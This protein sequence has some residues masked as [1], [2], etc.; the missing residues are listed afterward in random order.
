MANY[1]VKQL[2]AHF[3][4]LSWAWAWYS[5]QG[6]L[7]WGAIVT[8]TDSPNIYLRPRGIGTVESKT[9]KDEKWNDVIREVMNNHVYEEYI[10]SPDT[11]FAINKAIYD[12]LNQLI[13][14]DL[15]GEHIEYAIYQ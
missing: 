14:F 3:L 12:K 11:M 8:I 1:D 5:E 6:L 4:A 2:A 10:S 9:I 13:T 7:W 15:Q